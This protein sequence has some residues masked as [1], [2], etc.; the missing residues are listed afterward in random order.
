M[1]GSAVREA[2]IHNL[3]HLRRIL[4]SSAG[5]PMA[6]TP[7]EVT[8]TLIHKAIRHCQSQQISGECRWRGGPWRTRRSG[9]SGE[10]IIRTDRIVLL[11]IQIRLSYPVPRRPWISAEP[12]E[13]RRT[14]SFSERD[15]P[16]F[17]IDP[18][19]SWPFERTS[20]TLPERE[21]ARNTN[22]SSQQKFR[23]LLRNDALSIFLFKKR[24]ATVSRRKR[25]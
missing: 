2:I 6:K 5:F 10:R 3:Y 12:R 17:S 18:L 25:F 16:S 4:L 9:S 20:S 11:V 15:S 23:L 1:L 22:C 7:G 13:V 8:G 21:P 24:V 19:F 14:L